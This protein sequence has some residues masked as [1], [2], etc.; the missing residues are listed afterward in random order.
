MNF[1]AIVRTLVFL[2]LLF[3]MLYVGMNNTHMIDFH[4]PIAGTTAK[5]P[6]HTSAAL[7]Y[8]GVFAIGVFAGMALH[9]GGG[10]KKKSRE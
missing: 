10:G 1:K 4:F 3:V 5:T 7:I 9:T 8:F 2:A 6:I